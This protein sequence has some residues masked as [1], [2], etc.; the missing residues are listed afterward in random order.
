MPKYSFDHVHLM[1]PNPTKTAEFYEK[2]FGAKHIST[3]DLG[4]GRPI[5]NINL[6]GTTVLISQTQGNDA[7]TGLVH[8]GIQTDNL[9]KA[10]AELKAKDVKF[11]RDITEVRPGFRVS[12]FVGPENVPV[13]LQEGDLPAKD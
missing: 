8:F 7:Q 4:G 9:D 10:V 5:I 3:Q 13:E 11:T 1:S 6:N 12:F 2:M